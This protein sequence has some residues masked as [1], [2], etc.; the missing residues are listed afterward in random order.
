MTCLGAAGPLDP[1][2]AYKRSYFVDWVAAN[3][4]KAA[5]YARID[6]IVDGQR[7]DEIT[8]AAGGD[9]R[10]GLDRMANSYFRVR[11]WFEPGPGAA[12]GSSSASRSWPRMCPTT[13]GRSS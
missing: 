7:P 13:P 4:H 5:L 6:W 2:T 11:P 3:R 10:Q 1:K 9:L 12:S 8:F